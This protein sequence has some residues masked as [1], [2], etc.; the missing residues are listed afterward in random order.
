MA[1]ARHE[2]DPGLVL[3]SIQGQTSEVNLLVVLSTGA[4]TIHG[5]GSEG[6][7]PRCKS[8]SS[9][10]GVERSATAQSVFFVAKNPKSCLPIGTSSRRRV[11]GDASGSV[12]HP[13]HP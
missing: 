4:R 2:S 7:R 13:R 1:L 11:L 12:G 10:H 3:A 5:L 8:S 9:L 6:P